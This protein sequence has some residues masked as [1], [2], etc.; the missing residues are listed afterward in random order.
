MTLGIFNDQTVLLQ[1]DGVPLMIVD[2]PE[3]EFFVRS[4]DR[5]ALDRFLDDQ[6]LIRLRTAVQ[7]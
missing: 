1:E 6:E 4:L 3:A 5:D 2:T 7:G